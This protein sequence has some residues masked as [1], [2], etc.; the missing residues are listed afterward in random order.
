M[1]LPRTF[2]S[3]EFGP[4]N[5]RKDSFMLMFR[6]LEDK[7]IMV[8]KVPFLFLLKRKAGIPRLLGI[9]ILA[10][11]GVSLLLNTMDSTLDCLRPTEYR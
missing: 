4:E 7:M 3:I 2:G 1:N 8:E 6:A 11:N 10:I 9:C 5:K